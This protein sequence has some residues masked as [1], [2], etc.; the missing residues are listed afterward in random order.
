ML[1]ETADEAPV[2]CRP[3]HQ[4]GVE[5]TFQNENATLGNLVSE[6]AMRDPRVKR[7]AHKVA[8]PTDT[9]VHILIE[10]KKDGKESGAPAIM[11]AANQVLQDIIQKECAELKRLEE[12]VQELLLSM[13]IRTF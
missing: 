5:F 13:Q 9:E 11:A 3:W 8:H 10:L 6:A 1:E 2:S 7:A 4:G 12:K